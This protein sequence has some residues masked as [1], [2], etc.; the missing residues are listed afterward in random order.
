MSRIQKIFRKVALRK[1]PSDLAYWQTRSYQARLAALEEIRRE[2]HQ[3][4]YGGE[5][6]FERVYKIVKRKEGAL[7]RFTVIRVT[8]K[9]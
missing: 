7:S 6:R 8:P 5:P 9:I 4:R 2:Y 1:Q 3:W